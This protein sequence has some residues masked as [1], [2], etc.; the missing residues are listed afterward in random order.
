[1]Y[2]VT[3]VLFILACFLFPFFTLGVAHDLVRT[4][5][6]S[7]VGLIIGA[8]VSFAYMCAYLFVW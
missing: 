2:I 3:T 1:M 6:K 7:V 8:S 4:K 5:T